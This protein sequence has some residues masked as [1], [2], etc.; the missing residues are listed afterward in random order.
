[1]ETT[2]RRQAFIMQYRAEDFPLYLL[3]LVIPGIII[4]L[5]LPHRFEQVLLV[6]ALAYLACLFPIRHGVKFDR[7]VFRVAL[8][9]VARYP[10]IL[11]RSWRTA[12]D[13][14]MPIAVI[15][16]LALAVEHFL[17]PTLTGT[18]WLRPF[19]WQ[20]AIWAPFLLITLFRV[21][22]LIAHLL[23][24]SVVR[25]VLESSPQKKPLQCCRSITISSMRSSQAWW[26]TSRWSC[27]ALC[28]S[29]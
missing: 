22:I 13:A 6:L 7:S 27:L 3:S 4:G 21:T 26:A 10:L 15:F 17:R 14:V 20:W 9:G 5:A 12:R 19:P 2:A 18:R 24:A 11:A 23:R 1:M 29:C 28:S 25:E 16:S 8:E